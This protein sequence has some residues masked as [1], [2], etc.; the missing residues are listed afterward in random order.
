MGRGKP[1]PTP[2]LAR[3]LEFIAARRN[4]D[5][6][7]GYRPGGKST[8]EPTGLCAL[9]LT[10]AS[11]R[12]AAGPGLAF[13]R[14]CQKPNGAV[15]LDRED[16]DGC[17]AAYA[18]LLAFHAAGAEPEERRL[19]DWLLAFKDAAD[20]YSQAERAAVAARYRYDASIRGW[21]WTPGTT[22]WV[23]PTSLAMIALLRS[24]V[25]LGHDRIQSGLRL[26]FDRKVPSGGWNFGN[27]YSA[28]FE[29]EPSLMSTA[30]ALAALAAARTPMSH[31]A[32]AAGLRFLRRALDED[33]STASLAWSVLALGSFSRT[34]G[35]APSAAARLASLQADD[36]GFR[37][38][39]FETALAYL[40]LARPEALI[41][42]AERET[43]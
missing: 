9:A 29:L 43:S 34:V 22:A 20:R 33:V 25:P 26:L 31:P 36:G 17:W 15:G 4:A 24:G 35:L 3:A 23:E 19:R 32:V 6:G 1:M 42:R 12:A 41:R 10:S 16:E 30:L 21:P 11:E 5:G 39:L 8:V 27:P 14:S 18:A 28:S 40:V 7:W 13:L 38:N 37:S 2:P